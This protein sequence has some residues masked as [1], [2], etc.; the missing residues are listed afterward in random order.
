MDY[1]LGLT[2]TAAG[3]AVLSLLHVA[4]FRRQYGFR[5]M[6]ATALAAWGCISPAVMIVAAQTFLAS[7]GLDLLHL[8]AAAAG[9]V[10]GAACG[11]R[12]NAAHGMALDG[13]ASPDDPRERG[14]PT[15]R[16]ASRS[17]RGASSAR[18]ILAAVAAFVVLLEL[19]PFQYGGPARSDAPAE[20]TT[21]QWT[22]FVRQ[23]ETRPNSV[24]LDLGWKW[25]R[26]A[27]L[28]AAAA[29]Y[30]NRRTQGRTQRLP[31]VSA[32]ASLSLGAALF[33]LAMQF[34]H[35]WMPV[36]HSDVTNVLPAAVG[37]ACGAIFYRAIADAARRLPLPL[38]SQDAPALDSTLAL[39]RELVNAIVTAAS[40]PQER[41]VSKAD[42]TASQETSL[43]RELQ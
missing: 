26:F 19:T 1:V 28:G 11:G 25:L 22:P 16:Q 5:P 15:D 37:T 13:A 32:A 34:L 24:A 14:V 7:R 20:F 18:R 23:L 33:A 3:Y 21:F 43:P 39:D 17:H 12:A 30:F 2:A 42:V 31:G 40:P 6:A 41:R 29:H 35:L 36:R 27:A 38:S 4:A 9:M 10:I 8:A